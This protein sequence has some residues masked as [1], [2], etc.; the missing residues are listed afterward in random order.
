MSST[1]TQSTTTTATQLSNAEATDT[2]VADD[3]SEELD[4]DVVVIGGGPAG[5]SAALT[6]GR[7]R[8][9]VLVIDSGEPRNLPAAHAHNYLT[10]EGMPPLEILRQGRA[11]VAG[12][13]GRFI[14]SRVTAATRADDRFVVST[15]DGRE[16]RARRIMLATGLRDELPEVTGLAEHWG[17]SVLHCP[18]CHGWEVADRRIAVIGTGAVSVHQVLMWRQ[19]TDRL[20]FVLHDA[21][22]PDAVVLEQLAARGVAVVEAR[23]LAV[24]ERDGALTGIRTSDGGTVDCDAVVVGAKVHARLDGLDGL[25]LVVSDFVMMGASMGTY[26]AVDAMGATDV[27]GVFAAGNVTDPAAQVISSAAAGVK[28]GAAVNM[29]LIAAETEAA[30][31]A[32]RQFRA[33]RAGAGV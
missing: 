5:L 2:D 19:W 12:Y 26:L 21:P 30:V 6:L 23:A 14:R 29:S 10:S 9:S 22:M 15:A 4:V 17:T 11:E 20:T 25:G 32:A 27:P 31:D 13:G 33:A 8:R 16:V 28:T 24:L 3:R 1:P 7:A 18:Y